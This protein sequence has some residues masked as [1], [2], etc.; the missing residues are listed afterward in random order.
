MNQ[1]ELLQSKII[2]AHEKLWGR[3]IEVKNGLP[4]PYSTALGLFL[5]LTP[6]ELEE[7]KQRSEF[8][9]STGDEAF[10]SVMD[11]RDLDLIRPYIEDHLWQMAR[12]RIAFGM[13]L[14]ILF[15]RDTPNPVELTNWPEDKLVVQHLLTSFSPKELEQFNYSQPGTFKE[16]VELWD[17]RMLAE[18]K[19]ALFD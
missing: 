5:I 3:I 19:K 8:Q 1:S 7:A 18:I 13:R 12:A 10:K 9:F 2:D 4:S 14:L 6:R 16:I 15:S 17:E 11:N